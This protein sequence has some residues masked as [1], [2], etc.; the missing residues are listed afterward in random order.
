MLHQFDGSRTPIFIVL[1]EKKILR[2][3][4]FIQIKEEPAEILNQI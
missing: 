1:K 3:V 2:L 4:E